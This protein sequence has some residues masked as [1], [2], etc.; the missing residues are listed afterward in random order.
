MIRTSVSMLCLACFSVCFALSAPVL[1]GDD[2]RHIQAFEHGFR[3]A[4]HVQG[5]P[6]VRW[7]IEER[8]AHHKVPG[9][10]V[11]VIRDREIAWAKGYG[12][13]QAGG[14]EPVDTDT[15]FSVGSVS[16]V[17]AAA[18]TLRLVDAGRL[19]LDRNVNEYLE[20]WQVPANG[21]TAIRPVT[22]RGLLS[23]SAGLTVH[24]FEDF[25]PGE[26]LPTVV[27]VLEGRPPAKSEPVIVDYLPGSRSRYSGGGTTV[28]QLVIEEV[29]GMEFR[30]AAR[31]HV[32]EPLGM[33]R[34]TFENPLPAAHG[35]IARAHDENG[36]P[37]ALPRGWEA[38]PEAAASGLWTTPSDYARLVIALMKSYDGPDDSFLSQELVKEM[39][40]EVGV[41]PYG[42]GPALGGGG[43]QRIFYHGGSNES[44]KARMEGHLATG[45]GAVIFTNGA[46]GWELISEVRRAIAHA[47]GWEVGRTVTVPAISLP[48]EALQVFAGIYAVRAP[49]TL[50]EHRMML[51]APAFEVELKE[52][53]LMLRNTND[54]EPD[55]LVASGINT[56]VDEETGSTLV[57][58][59]RDYTGRISGL[60]VHEDGYIV[61]ALKMR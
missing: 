45:N 30:E 17:G 42:L 18:V 54:G 47:E 19:D 10:S 53:M 5:Q 41:S 61:E 49:S 40:I 8:M 48:P 50:A 12:L 14:Q 26:A 51:D 1:A 58:F 24:G 39:M 35:N 33:L 32:F 13:K 31:R 21:Y 16:K 43:M 44:Y 52:G 56:F 55:A 28:E 38:M 22:L 2:D 3:P 59:I 7:T 11:A 34:S 25:Q 29:T 46:N 20:R 4:V 27:D 36:E 23:H 37:A 15:V 9:L 6:P 60:R 57:E